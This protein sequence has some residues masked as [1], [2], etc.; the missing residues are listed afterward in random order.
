MSSPIIDSMN[1]KEMRA[2]LKK[3]GWNQK[4]LAQYLG[5]SEGAVSLWINGLRP[6][7][8]P[9]AIAVQAKIEFGGIR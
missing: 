6:I 4:E 1:R 3:L 7:P 9:V 5:V 2:A 8:Q